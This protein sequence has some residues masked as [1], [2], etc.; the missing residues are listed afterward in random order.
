[1]EVLSNISKEFT[2]YS[3]DVGSSLEDIEMLNN[4]FSINIPLDYIE[5]ISKKSD[6][7]IGI[8]KADYMELTIW[9]A[10]DCIYNNN[11]YFIQKYIPNSMA[12]GAN[13]GDSVLFYA[14]GYNGFGIYAVEFGN[15]DIEDAKYITPSL[16]ELLLNNIGLEELINSY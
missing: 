7:F 11:A 14:D 4:T 15:L 10:K 9:G 3:Y 6:L 16:T 13:G 5:I 12:I 2:I 8:N 1:M